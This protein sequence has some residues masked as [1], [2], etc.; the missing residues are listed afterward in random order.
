MALRTGSS[1]DLGSGAG[2][3]GLVDSR[4]A[5]LAAGDLSGEGGG[6][7]STAS[8]ISRATN[9]TAGGSILAASRFLAG[10]S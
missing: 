10:L 8:R 1:L 3:F 7:A 2:A 4:G 6:G 9:R 5:P